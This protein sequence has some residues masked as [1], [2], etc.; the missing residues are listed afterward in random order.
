MEMEQPTTETYN[1]NH[2]KNRCPSTSLGVNSRPIDILELTNTPKNIE[3]NSSLSLTDNLIIG[4]RNSKLALIQADLVEREINKRFTTDQIKTEIQSMSTSGDENLQKP[5]Y[6]L[7]GK[8]VWTKELEFNLLNGSIDLIVHSLKDV[9]TALPA[10]CELTSV[11]LREDPRDALIIR[12]SLPFTNLSQLPPGSIIGTSSV[13]R[14]AQLRRRFPNL[15]FQ[16]IRGNLQTR[17]KK[18]DATDSPYTG[19]ILAVAGL[20]RIGLATRITSY[21]EPPDLYHA[22]G[23]GAIGIEIRTPPAMKLNETL[24]ETILRERATTVQKLVKSL[25]DWRTA[26]TCEAERALLRRLEGGC[27]VPVGVQSSLVDLPMPCPWA[28][29]ARLTLVGVVTSVDGLEEVRKEAWVDVCSTKD[30]IHLGTT[31]ADQLFSDGADKIL[32]QLNSVKKSDL[33]DELLKESQLNQPENLDIPSRIA[34]LESTSSNFI[35]A[36]PA[37]ASRT[38]IGSNQDYIIC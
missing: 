25:E 5:L 34:N 15:A 16:D 30:A 10:G 11:M 36:A 3:M 14:V 24:E 1:P 9:P 33:N 27:S 26:L 29:K 19:I 38:D 20:K 6:L 32:D 17:F 31:L 37:D 28:P 4:T 21:L 23:Q 2:Q 7:G 18:L 13:R 8:S 22:V 12:N 35:I